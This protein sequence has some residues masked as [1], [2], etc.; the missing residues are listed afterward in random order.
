MHA[1]KYKLIR[2]TK[3]KFKQYYLKHR[4]NDLFNE[5]EIKNLFDNLVINDPI[6]SA[7]NDKVLKRLLQ[8]CINDQKPNAKYKLNN[9]LGRKSHLFHV[10][11]PS[12]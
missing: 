5:K 11:F 8:I 9:V 3:D 2:D 6:L 7:T 4:T 10:V 12:V 1:K